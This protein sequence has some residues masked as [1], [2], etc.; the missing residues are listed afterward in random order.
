MTG[1]DAVVHLAGENIAGGRWNTARKNAIRESRVQGTAHLCQA[2]AQLRQPP[3]ILITASAIGYYGDRGEESLTEESTSGSGFLSEVTRAWEAATQPAAKAGVRV[4]N[5]RIGVVLSRAGGALAQMLTPFKLGLG[6]KIG[7]GRQYISWIALSD[8]LAVIEYLLHDKSISGPVNAV[9]PMPVTNTVF[10]R[11]LGRVL[12][13][14]TI[15]PLPAMLVRLL[16]GQMGRELLLSSTRV[17]PKRLT[18]S[19]FIYTYADLEAA[20]RA[21]LAPESSPSS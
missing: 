8:L 11:T 2:L 20:L 12:H 6:G 19:G 4:V 15:L 9:A 5:V 3:P 16:F 13:R 14:P 21:E 1:V 17:L 18:A 10:T 7:H